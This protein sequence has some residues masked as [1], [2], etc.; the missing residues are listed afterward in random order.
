MKI[1]TI[2]SRA[3]DRNFGGHTSVDWIFVNATPQSATLV[4]LKSNL[5]LMLIKIFALHL[6]H[7]SQNINN[8]QHASHQDINNIEAAIIVLY[9]P[10]ISSWQTLIT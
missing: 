1:N 10:I 9:N 8:Q 7:Q 2:G 6:F 5:G 3:C 4:G